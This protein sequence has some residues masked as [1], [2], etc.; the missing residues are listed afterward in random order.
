MCVR[1]NCSSWLSHYVKEEVSRGTLARLCLK[2]IFGFG[3]RERRE[4]TL[5]RGLASIL[6]LR[7]RVRVDDPSGW[8]LLLKYSEVQRSRQGKSTSVTLSGV[9]QNSG[10]VRG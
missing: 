7:G 2:V 6:V 10:D 8:I 1:D 4:E 3:R 5:V 9:D